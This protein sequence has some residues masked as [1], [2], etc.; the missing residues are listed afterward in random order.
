M[1]IANELP[2]RLLYRDALMLVIDKPAGIAVHKGMGKGDN[3]QDHFHALS[4]GLPK[5][6][7]LAHRL[8]RETS[9]CLVLGR[10]AEALRRLGKLFTD[11]QIK[12]TYLAIVQG[13]PPEASGRID[14]PLGKQ[15]EKSYLWRMKVDHEKGQPST[16]DYKLLGSNHGLS[17]LE[18]T[19]ITGRTHQLRV[20][21]AA[22]GMPILGDK[23]YGDEHQQVMLHLHAQS[24]T[25]PLYPKKPAIAV[26]AP[27]P[28]HMK[29]IV[30]RLNGHR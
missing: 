2:A 21:C 12:K 26:T 4:F 23:A 13:V 15:S 30:E 17:L 14:L 1:D 18:L 7:A 25:I 16:T 8:D 22:M 20:H 3:L 11:S 19:P 29:A 24:I 28:P 5:P 27:Y 9:G 10:H 6:P